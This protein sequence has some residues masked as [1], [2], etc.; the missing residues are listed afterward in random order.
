MLAILVP[1]LVAI[2]LILIVLLFFWW[3]NRRLISRTPWPSSFVPAPGS[4]FPLP[5]ARLAGE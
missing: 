5:T 2:M 1:I 3:R 4:P